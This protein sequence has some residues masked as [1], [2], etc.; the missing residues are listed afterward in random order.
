MLLLFYVN[1]WLN[2]LFISENKNEVKQKETCPRSLVADTTVLSLKIIHNMIRSMAH[3]CKFVRKDAI[4]FCKRYDKDCF[5]SL[6][7]L[8]KYNS[9]LFPKCYRSIFHLTPSSLYYVVRYL[10]LG[11]HRRQIE[12][13]LSF[14]LLFHLY[15]YLCCHPFMRELP[16]LSQDIPR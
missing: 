12:N 15:L 1:K 6:V 2:L 3:W 16:L 7:D 4:Q 14:T 11:F 8:E 10:Y 13:D 9:H 5:F